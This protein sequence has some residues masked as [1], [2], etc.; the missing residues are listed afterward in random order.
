MSEYQIGQEIGKGGMGCV[1]E[2][3]DSTGRKI[4]LKMMSAKAASFP[5][6]RELFDLEVQHLRKLDH[7]SVVK[8]VGHPFSDSSGNM[9]LPMQ[10]IEGRTISQIIKQR[11]YPFS[12]QEAIAIFTQVLDAFTYIHGQACIHRDVKPSN[13]MI[14]TDNTV[15][16]IDF[17]IAKDGRTPTGRTIGRIVGTDGYMSPEQADGSTIDKRTDIYSLGCLL[18]FMLTGTH[19]IQ[20]QSNDYDTICK[21]LEGKFPLVSDSNISVSDQTQKAILKAVDKNM[22]RRFQSAEEFKSALIGTAFYKIKVGRSNCDINMPSEYVSSHHLDIVFQSQSG[23]NGP[24][25]VTITDFSTN[26]TGIN[27][28]RFKNESCSFDCAHLPKIKGDNAAYPQILIAGLPELM[29]NWNDVAMILSEPT[30]VVIDNFPAED[31]TVTKDETPTV[32]DRLSFGY[33]VLSFLFPIAGWILSG[34]WKE[35]TPNRARK[36][37]K[38]AWLGFIFNL[39]FGY[40]LKI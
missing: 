1:Y 38:V 16:V 24:F 25:T 35:K 30:T 10:Y 9:F 5:E 26:G 2:A 6:Y 27:G 19:A 14:R 40:L 20:K 13:V 17:G 11:G 36:A 28:R 23:K 29:L 12:E 37:A 7:P 8:M 39:I 18:H 15:C 22:T 33:G 32:R 31:D 4:A 34:V 3:Y 21:I